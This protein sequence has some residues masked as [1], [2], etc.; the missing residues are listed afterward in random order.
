M[1]R[2]GRWCLVAMVVGLV[3]GVAPIRRNEAVE[4]PPAEWK[5]VWSDD[6]DGKEIDKEK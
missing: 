6:F 1:M 2:A 5:L 4:P 3:A